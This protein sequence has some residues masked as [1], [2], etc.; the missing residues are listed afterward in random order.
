MAAKAELARAAT[1]AERARH[2]WATVTMGRVLSLHSKGALWASAI[3]F[4][5]S[6]MALWLS[7]M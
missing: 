7:S 2:C 5:S 6:V 1:Q 3:K 4:K